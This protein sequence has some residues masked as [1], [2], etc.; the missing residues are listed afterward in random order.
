MTE[1]MRPYLDKLQSR[2]LIV[3]LAGSCAT[4]AGCSCVPGAV[5]PFVPDGV[6]VLDGVTLG[7]LGLLMLHHMVGGG[8]GVA[9][10]RRW[11][12]ARKT[13][14]DVSVLLPVVLGMH[15]LYEWS[16]ADI[17]AKD[18]ILQHKARG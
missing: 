3:G 9:I 11:K 18:E 12:R 4:A 10:R 15:S 8:W 2:A 1:A 16:H 6:H 13:S 17:V 7:S 14:A 5:F